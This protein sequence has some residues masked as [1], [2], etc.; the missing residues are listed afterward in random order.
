MFAQI[1]D[2]QSRACR[3]CAN[4]FLAGAGHMT[5]KNARCEMR[6]RCASSSLQ[7]QPRLLLEHAR[8][9]V[10]TARSVVVRPD[11]RMRWHPI[12]RA[13]LAGVCAEWWRAYR[14]RI[15]M[16]SLQPAA[17]QICFGI[18][19]CLA[20]Q[21][22][23]MAASRRRVLMSV[24]RSWHTRTNMRNGSRCCEQHHSGRELCPWSVPIE[25]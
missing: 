5:A 8:A 18:C 12:A 14:E 3:R 4:V 21:C 9:T 1:P 25:L 7:L 22:S 13:V 16:R 2:A 11:A 17:M 15:R 24:G 19:N 10:L 23:R 20:S 6:E